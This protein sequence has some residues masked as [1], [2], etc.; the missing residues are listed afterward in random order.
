MPDTDNARHLAPLETARL[1]DELIE[2]VDERRKQ[3]RPTE[4][5]DLQHIRPGAIVTI[6][7][8]QDLEILRTTGST[9]PK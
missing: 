9:G 7:A 8:G 4:P 1:G 2:P 5:V 3:E 6:E